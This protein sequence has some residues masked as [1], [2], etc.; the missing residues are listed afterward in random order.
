LKVINLIQVKPQTGFP[1]F[2]KNMEP[3]PAFRVSEAT[4]LAA[5][6]AT[7]FQDASPHEWAAFYLQGSQGSGVTEVTSGAFFVDENRLHIL[8]AHYRHLV[9][10]PILLTELY[11]HPL[12]A[13]SRIM[14]EFVPNQ[15]WTVV[16]NSNWGFTKPFAASTVEVE[17]NQDPVALGTGLEEQLR[18]LKQMREQNL[19]D[20]VEYR[21]KREELL[22]GL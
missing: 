13:T 19:I 12:N 2:S 20:E 4:Y 3:E 5:R 16:K 21:R 9:T 15:A 17:L 11:Q 7:L 18:M 8:F 14:Y 1:T 10:V 6:L 22:N